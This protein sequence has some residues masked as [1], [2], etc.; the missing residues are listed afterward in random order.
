MLLTSINL[1]IVQFS[2]DTLSILLF[3]IYFSSLSIFALLSIMYS[4]RNVVLTLINIELFMISISINF[5][6]IS[7]VSSKLAQALSL[8]ILTVAAAESALGL[9]L[10]VNAYRLKTTLSI[11]NI[12][13]MKD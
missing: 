8:F 1:F 4:R 10:F 12:S 3:F 5:A 11:D 13:S 6:L 7:S 2:T 9:S